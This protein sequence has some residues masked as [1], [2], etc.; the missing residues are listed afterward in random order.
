MDIFPQYRCN[1]C[2]H[3]TLDSS[4]P[5]TRRRGY[6][7][8][9]S[10]DTIAYAMQASEGATVIIEQG[11]KLAG[12]QILILEDVMFRVELVFQNY[13]DTE[14][15]LSI[16][17]PEESV[18]VL[19]AYRIS[20]GQISFRVR[21]EFELKHSY[22]DGL[23][24]T[25]DQLSPETIARVLPATFPPFENHVLP[26]VLEACLEICS[27]DQRDALVS[28]L[29]LPHKSPPLLVRGAFGTG[30]TFLLAAAVHCLLHISGVVRVLVCTQ[31]HTSALAFLECFHNKFTLT[32][33]ASRDNVS[34]FRLVPESKRDCGHEYFARV[35]TASQIKTERER[36][37]HSSQL[38][39]VTT[40]GTS[41]QLCNVFSD[42]FFTHILVDEGAQLREPD[43]MAP[44]LLSGPQTR[45][46]I[47]GDEHQV[48]LG[49]RV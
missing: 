43:A 45:I 8:S 21:V 13:S 15:K 39:I 46:V 33:S 25:V 4:N 36:I 30:K 10:G 17:L 47:S 22:F 2:Y 28:I 32:N 1:G 11:A 29:S 26:A 42:E 7:T 48:S 41:K 34:I 35:L 24:K 40:C 5:H 12:A 31:Q 27:Q 14:E 6:I 18:A 37:R 20:Y 9:I 38:L 49:K 19:E 3:L 23:H 16:E 44:L